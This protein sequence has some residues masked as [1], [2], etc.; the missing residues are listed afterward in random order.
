[1]LTETRGIAQDLLHTG[2]HAYPLRPAFPQIQQVNWPGEH[3][4]YL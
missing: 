2:P 3:S 1:M 4:I